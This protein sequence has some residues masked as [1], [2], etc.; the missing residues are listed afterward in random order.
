ML[1]ALAVVVFFAAAC[2]DYATVRY[3]DIVD[4]YKKTRIPRLRTRAANWSVVMA[5]IGT[6]GLLS[7]V[8]VSSLLIIPE[9]LGLWVGT[10]VALLRS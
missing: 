2:L 7:V 9:F 5:G 8:E 6:L 4:E 3:F 1:I 10:Q